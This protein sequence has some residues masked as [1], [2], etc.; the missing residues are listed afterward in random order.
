MGLWDKGSFMGEK[1]TLFTLFFFFG[2]VNKCLILY[3]ILIVFFLIEDV[4]K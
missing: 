2:L 1:S 3:S 4:L